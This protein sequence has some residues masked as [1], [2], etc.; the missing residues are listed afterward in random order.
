[1]KQIMSFQKKTILCIY[2]PQ[3]IF[4]GELQ[5]NQLLHL[6]I[7]DAGKLSFALLLKVLRGRLRTTAKN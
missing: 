4:Y 3:G 1:M 5:Q 6:C 7:H 2:K